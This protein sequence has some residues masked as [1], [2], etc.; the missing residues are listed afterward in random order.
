MSQVFRVRI[1]GSGDVP[2]SAIL[3]LPAKSSID[4]GR[5]SANG[6]YQREI[7]VYRLL[8]DLQGGF[9]P[10]ILSELFDSETGTAAC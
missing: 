10:R 2:C 4:R 7:E 8:H 6:S 5:E 3:K 1:S 9:Q